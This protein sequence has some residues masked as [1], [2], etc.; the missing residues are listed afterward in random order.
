[1]TYPLRGGHE[2]EDRRL[3]RVPQ[4][5]PRS[6]GFPISAVVAPRLRSVAWVCRPRLDQGREGACVGFAWSHELAAYPVQVRQVSNDSAQWIYREAQKIDE[7]P[8]EGY[9]GTSVLAGAKIVQ[10]EGHIS[11]YHW[12][13]SVDEALAAISNA[14]PVVFG[15]PWKDSM[16]EPRSD[17][18]L[19]CSGRVIGGHAILGRGLRIQ[20]RLRGVREPVVRLLNSWGRD[21]G[22]R[23]DCFL[24]ASDLEGLLQDN[25]DCCLPLGRR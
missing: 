3:D 14:G 8:G 2:T 7:W 24:R 17:G 10:R 16:Y 15:I 23:G 6:R 12:A 4:F 11:S 18:L 9:S 25:G 5:D 21:W 19:D 1:M 13:F 20:P 22:L